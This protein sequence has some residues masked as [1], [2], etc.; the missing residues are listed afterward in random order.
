MFI[1]SVVII[2]KLLKTVCRDLGFTTL[3]VP[4][5]IVHSIHCVKSLGLGLECWYLVLVLVLRF[6]ALVP[7]LAC[8]NLHLLKVGVYQAFSFQLG[9]G[10]LLFNVALSLARKG[11]LSPS[12]THA[13]QPY[14]ACKLTAPPWNGFLQPGIIKHDHE[15]VPYFLAKNCSRYGSQFLNHTYCVV[16]RQNWPKL[17]GLTLPL[18][19][20]LLVL[21]GG[22]LLECFRAPDTSWKTTQGPWHQTTI[23]SAIL[24]GA[25]DRADDARTLLQIWLTFYS[26]DFEKMS[27]KFGSTTLSGGF[28]ANR[29]A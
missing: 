13:S 17:R 6:G 5:C 25:L 16:P 24:H 29:G 4:M 3:F 21:C 9:V 19:D 28:C 11:R 10:V 23:F 26:I 1:Q 7:Y 12:S 18:S 2:T 20:F 14:T 22:I 15:H 8:S 27:S